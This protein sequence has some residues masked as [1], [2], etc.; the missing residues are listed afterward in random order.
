LVVNPPVLRRKHFFDNVSAIV[1]KKSGVKEPYYARYGADDTGPRAAAHDSFHSSVLKD[2]AR[3]KRGGPARPCA[4][5]GRPAIKPDESGACL[6]G[7]AC[8]MTL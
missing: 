2:R 6:A 1:L 7:M 5:R 8:E 4:R 3:R